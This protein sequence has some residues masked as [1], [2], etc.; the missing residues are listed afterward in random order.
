MR[1][2]KKCDS[3][4]CDYF[5]ENGFVSFCPGFGEPSVVVDASAQVLAA[6]HSLYT[7]SLFF[8]D[9]E[10]SGGLLGPP[11]LPH[12]SFRILALSLY[13]FLNMQN[14]D[15]AV[16]LAANAGVR[17]M[18]RGQGRRLSPGGAGRGEVAAGR[19]SP[20]CSCCVRAALPFLPSVLSSARR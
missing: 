10:W 8:F 16:G 7:E 15:S 1:K 6:L 13:I 17:D 12:P 20:R 19:Q 5:K 11:P 9:E 14:R 18:A 3:D 4:F 2:G